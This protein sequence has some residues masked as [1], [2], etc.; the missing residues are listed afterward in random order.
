MDAEGRITQKY[1]EYIRVRI[2]GSL[3]IGAAAFVLLGLAALF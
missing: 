1:A 3:G 2:W